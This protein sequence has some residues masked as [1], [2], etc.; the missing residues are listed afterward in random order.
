DPFA[1][2]D[3]VERDDSASHLVVGAPQRHGRHLQ[4]ALAFVAREANSG[5]ANGFAGERAADLGV[6][7]VGALQDLPR[8]RIAPRWRPVGWDDHDAD[9]QLVVDR[10][11]LARLLGDASLEVVVEIPE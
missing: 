9:R 6:E 4:H 11:D 10:R 3:V 8:S 2:G 1:F 7:W 5:P